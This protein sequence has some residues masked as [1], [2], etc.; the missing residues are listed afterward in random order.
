MK[1]SWYLLLRLSEEYQIKL[2]YHR[3]MGSETLKIFIMQCLTNVLEAHLIWI[4]FCI[5]YC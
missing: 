1:Y 2:I 4:F 5:Y 3:I